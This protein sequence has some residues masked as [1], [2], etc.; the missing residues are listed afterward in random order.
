MAN[1]TQASDDWTSWLGDAA[2]SIIQLVAQ[3]VEGGSVGTLIVTSVLAFS[4]GLGMAIV[5]LTGNLRFSGVILSGAKLSE[6]IARRIV[7]SQDKNLQSMHAMTS[8]IFVTEG[9]TPLSATIENVSINANAFFGKKPFSTDL[10]GKTG[11]YLMRL[12]K[13]YMDRHVYEAFVNDQNEVF[14]RFS[15]A[16]PAVA[17]IPIIF[18]S[19]HPHEL[20]R[21]TAW[22]PVIIDLGSNGKRI[23]GNKFEHRIHIA[24]FNLAIFSEAVHIYEQWRE[25]SV[26]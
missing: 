10:I 15:M 19:E 20:Y 9:E 23:N 21:N 3:D 24:Y 5:F 7:G 12:I 13:G 22:I 25:D 14:T 18:N 2:H 11:D 6:W 16:K 26:S 1:A 8:V 17:K 4:I